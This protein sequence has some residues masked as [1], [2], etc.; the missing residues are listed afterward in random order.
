MSV[1]RILT[2]E[3]IQM[4]CSLGVNINEIEQHLCILGHVVLQ[5]TEILRRIMDMNIQC[6]SMSEPQQSKRGKLP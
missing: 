2:C 6:L 4:S 3:G 5:I 1:V